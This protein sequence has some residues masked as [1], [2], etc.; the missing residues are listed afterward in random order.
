MAVYTEVSDAALS[1]FL[2]GY[3]IG[4]LISFKG[5]AEGV[6]NSNYLMFTNK[7][8]Y[9]LTL[10]EKRVTE[11]DLPFFLGLIE[12]LANNGVQCPTPIHGKNGEVLRS[13]CEKPAAITSFL[14][15]ISL[16]NPKVMHCNAVGLALAKLHIAGSKYKKE[17]KNSLSLDKCINLFNKC[18][19]RADEITPGLSD[20]I[21]IELEYLCNNWPK[22]LP[23]GI[24]HA[25]LFPDNVFFENDR[26][27]GIIDF[28]FACNDFL[29]YD[30]GICINAWCFENDCSF[31]PDKARML[32]QGYISERP[33]KKIEISA[34]PIL[35]RAASFRFLTTRLFDWLNSVEGALVKPKDPNEYVARLK[36]LQN[37]E[38][39]SFFGIE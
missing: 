7:G 1:S 29:A 19:P 35:T 34:L 8:P 33:L 30:L 16:N 26:L 31:N 32:T 22:N 38:D 17:R 13:L 5:I 28:Y 2:E 14:N 36:L 10:Y 12:H 6:E 25:D 20:L 39:P 4:Q 15:G 27:T 11:T 21:H 3:D 37:I 23:T 24:I 9:I 18:L